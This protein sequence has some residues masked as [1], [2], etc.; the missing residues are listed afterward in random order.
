MG[1][2]GAR[3]V[4]AR[5]QSVRTPKDPKAYKDMDELRQQLDQGGASS[6]GPSISGLINWL[7]TN[8]FGMQQQQQRVRARVDGR[9]GGALA[10]RG[11]RLPVPARGSRKHPVLLVACLLLLG[12]SVGGTI[13]NP[14]DW[15]QVMLVACLL[16][17]P[18]LP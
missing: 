11:H 16:A 18:P 7:S 2:G 1:T 15:W 4:A 8:A 17:P 12:V 13:K 10:P 9:G 3:D 5:C 6:S 14:T